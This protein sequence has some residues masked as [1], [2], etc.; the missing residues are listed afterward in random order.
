MQNV[1]FPLSLS[2]CFPVE[3]AMCLRVEKW[4]EPFETICVPLALFVC[5]CVI[6]CSQYIFVCIPFAFA[7]LCSNIPLFYSHF[8][9]Y[10]WLNFLVCRLCQLCAHSSKSTYTEIELEKFVQRRKG[11]ARNRMRERENG[12]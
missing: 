1:F 6:C 5:V 9:F 3:M 12:K 7:F 2:L 10:I 4:I 8:T 11:F